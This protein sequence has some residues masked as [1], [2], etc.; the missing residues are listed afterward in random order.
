MVRKMA[1][2]ADASDLHRSRDG[3][4]LTYVSRSGRSKQFWNE[5]VG[6]GPAVRM[7]EPL[8]GDVLD[9]QWS[10][11]AKRMVYLRREIKF[12]LALLTNWR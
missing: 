12:E 4:W 5:P 10:T 7:G 3:K 11:G 1:A 9:V 6:D 2:P 8:A